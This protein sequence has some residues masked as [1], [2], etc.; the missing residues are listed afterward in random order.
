MDKDLDRRF[1]EYAKS[2]FGYDINFISSDTP[3]TFEEVFGVSFKDTSSEPLI[4]FEYTESTEDVLDQFSSVFW[5]VSSEMV[6]YE[7]LQNDGLAA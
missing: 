3:D 6:K 7:L 1:V 5:D 2:T 4:E